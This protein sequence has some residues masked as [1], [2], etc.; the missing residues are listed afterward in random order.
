[1]HITE[2]ESHKRKA[3]LVRRMDDAGIN[4][5]SVKRYSFNWKKLKGVGELYRL[6]LE[7][8][9]DILGVMA[10]IPYP[11]EQ[12]LEIKLLAASAENIG[13]DKYYEGIAGCLIAYACREAVIRYSPYPCV[14]LIPKTELR[15]HYIQKYKMFDA[16]KSL[17]LEDEPLL[18]MIK[19]HLP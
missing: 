18:A 7:G 5:L 19:E 9:E 1:M 11:D 6:T 10:V 3:V 15:K 16:G 2:R 13:K 12:R 4:S 14:S 8:D 17:Y